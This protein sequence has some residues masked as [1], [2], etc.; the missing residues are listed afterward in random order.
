MK[1][2]YLYPTAG[3][4]W[5]LHTHSTPTLHSFN[6]GG[7]LSINRGL[8]PTILNPSPFP[9]F[10]L[11][12]SWPKSSHYTGEQNINSFISGINHVPRC[13]CSVDSTSDQGQSVGDFTC[14]SVSVRDMSM[15]P[16]EGNQSPGQGM[17]CHTS[18][19]LCVGQLVRNLLFLTTIEQLPRIYQMASIDRALC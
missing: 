6:K 13:T 12:P 5:E 17:R 16:A 7:S 18:P 1:L 9:Y 4:A 14:F 2:G 19:S 3:A 8:L 10:R 15:Y 11:S